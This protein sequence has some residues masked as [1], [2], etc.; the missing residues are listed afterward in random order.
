MPNMGMELKDPN[1]KIRML[2]WLSQLSA[3]TKYIIKIR[4]TFKWERWDSPLILDKHTIQNWE[5]WEGEQNRQLVSHIQ[6]LIDII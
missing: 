6:G 2:Y 5:K 1:V 4:N 3:S